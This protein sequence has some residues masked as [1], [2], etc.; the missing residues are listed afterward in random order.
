MTLPRFGK[1]VPL[2][3]DVLE[4]AGYV[5]SRDPRADVVPDSDE[6]RIRIMRRGWTSLVK[7]TGRD[8]GYDLARWVEFLEADEDCRDSF[9]HPYAHRTTMRWI[10][11]AIE[12]PER[13]RLVA[14][15]E[16]GDGSRPD[17]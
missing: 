14:L 16:R 8:F 13:Q 4:L 3:G 17:S 15:I 5:L 2:Q 9:T 11:E 10:R 12:D 6:E 1:I 7:R